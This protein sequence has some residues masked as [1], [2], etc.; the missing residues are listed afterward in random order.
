MEA[1]IDKKIVLTFEYARR[2]TF[3]FVMGNE[4]GK[5]GVFCVIGL[6]APITTNA[7]DDIG[8]ATEAIA[9]AYGVDN[10][11]TSFVSGFFTPDDDPLQAAQN[12][13]TQPN[14]GR[15][16][17]RLKSAKKIEYQFDDYQNLEIKSGGFNY[18]F[19]YPLW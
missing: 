7:N 13:Y 1:S 18:T 6:I 15:S 8:K 5:V 12:N 9:K 10:K 4:F 17:L 11:L 16:K 3:G 14:E 2:N 19:T